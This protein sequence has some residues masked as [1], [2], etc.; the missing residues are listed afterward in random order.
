M[1]KENS[2]RTFS[3]ILLWV[4]RLIFAFTFIFSGFVK[5]IDPLG[6]AYKLQDYFVAFGLESFFDFALPMAVIMNALEFVIGFAV[7]FGLKMRYSAWGAILFM[8][9][10][11][12]LTLYV[13]ITDPVPDCGCFGDA[14]ILGNWST[15]YKNIVL[16]SVAVF[17][18]IKR[19]TFKPLLDRKRDWVLIGVV[20]F[21]ILW[22]SLYCLRYLPVIDFRPWKKGA[23]IKE[24][25]SEQE[26]PDIKI[27]FE[28][29]NKKTGETQELTQQ[30][31]AEQGVPDSSK[32]KYISREEVVLDPGEP[33][34][35]E[36]FFIN[37]VYGIDYTEQYLNEPDYLFV[38]IAYDLDKANIN[39][40]E[41]KINILAEKLEEQDNKLIVLTGSAF[42]K[43]DNFRHKHQA[44]YPFY[45][46]DDIVLKTIIRSNPGLMILKDGIIIEKYPFRR[47]PTFERIQRNVLAN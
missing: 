22:L 3:N 45:Q 38:V 43:I 27:T 25:M 34:V 10:F 16:L 6:T 26:P 21:A 36:N 7:L 29:A 13:A 35:I 1:N 39:A 5:S 9:F 8:V 31:I 18:F 17:I 28:Y 11:T 20:A 37:D 42:D 23:D 33:P 40:F 30:E 19:K 12:P 46:S 14:V 47:I 15:F 4:A 41:N 44:S 32:W 2:L 24:L